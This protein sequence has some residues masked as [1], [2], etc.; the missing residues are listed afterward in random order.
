MRIL[1]INHD[2]FISSAALIED[3]RIVAAA[4]EERFTRVK[5]TRDFPIHAIRYCLKEAGCRIEDVDY[6]AS[7]WNPG[8]YFKKFNPLFSGRR[9]WKTEYLYSVPDHILSLYPDEERDVD[10]VFQHI[11]LFGADCKIYYITHHRAHAANAFLLSPFE[12]AAILTADA[13][14]EFE[15]TTFGYG[16]GHQITVYQSILYPQSL[17]GFYSTFTEYLG[18]RPNSDEWKVMALA[19]FADWENVYYKIL[20]DE[21]VKLLPDGRYE[22][23]LTFFKGY[24]VEQPNLYTEK[25]VD[26]FGPPRPPGG[27]LHTRHYEIAA[28]MQRVAEEIA[29][30]MLHWLY[31]QTRSKNIV[32]SGGF[33][34]NSVLNGKILRY[35]PFENIFISSC[36]DDSGNAIGAAL[37]LYNHILGHEQREPL[38]H[39]FFGPEYDEEEIR[40]TLEKY[41]VRARRVDDAAAYCARLVSE[42]KLVGWFQGRME[43]GQR[44][45]GNRSIL[46]DPRDPRTKDRVNLAVKYREPFRPFAP[47]VLAEEA[48]AYFEMDDGVG[49][50]FMEKVY[51]IRP[52]KRAVIPAVTHVDGSGRLQTVDRET[53]PRFH[54]LIEEFRRITDVPVVLNT[55]FNLNGE[56]IVCTPTD[57]IRT[58]F[59]CGLDALV[60]GDYVVSK[61]GDLR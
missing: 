6:V 33:F 38:R 31:A 13:Q 26:R 15:S 18:F 48:H 35:T 55:S 58:F 46:A 28:A 3:G 12:E 61:N 56:P 43:F 1:G 10:Y 27:E 14:G 23:D 16:R 9:R 49:V 29:F 52:E 60:L 4:P 39:N 45:L 19:A 41:N 50:P 21:V 8:V 36:P 30:H 17:G 34:M 59:S 40:R 2:M 25:L 20:K 5:R 57:A 11:R 22:F 44:A 42:G 7:S 53:N 51:P 37:Y 47:A 24:N 32:V 54:R